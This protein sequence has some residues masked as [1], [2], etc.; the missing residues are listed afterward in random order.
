MRRGDR[1][2]ELEAVLPSLSVHQLTILRTFR[3]V[4][5]MRMRGTACMGEGAAAVLKVMSA[6]SSQKQAV[7]C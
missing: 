5:A 1:S 3:R 2:T 4:S 6:H 7:Q